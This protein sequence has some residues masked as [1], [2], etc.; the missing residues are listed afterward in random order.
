MRELLFLILTNIFIWSGIYWLVKLTFSGK[1]RESLQFSIQKG[2]VC[3]NCKED[4]NF[5]LDTIDKLEE[6]YKK[7]ADKNNYYKLC[8]SC[9]R[10]EALDTILEN[11]LKRIKKSIFNKWKR[12]YIIFILSSLIL[13]IIGAITK[14]HTISLL[15]AII[16]F[17]AHWGNYKNFIMTSRPKK[18]QS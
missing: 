16:L 12:N 9:K 8:T 6:H 11:P 5:D 3:Q 4:I 13:Q 7:T 18:T 15:A 2:L 14:I 1:K 17:M 10:D